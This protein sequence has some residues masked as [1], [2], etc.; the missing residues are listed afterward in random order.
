MLLDLHQL[1]QALRRLSYHILLLECNI[2]A[3]AGL[4]PVPEGLEGS[5]ELRA[6]LLLVDLSGVNGIIF[7][8]PKIYNP[9]LDALKLPH[10]GIGLLVS[11]VEL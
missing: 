9:S 4:Q 6:W 3:D 7:I 1:F 8:H 5:L 2:L 10:Q 11:R